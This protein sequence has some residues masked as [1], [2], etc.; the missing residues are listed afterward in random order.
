MTLVSNNVGDVRDI[1]LDLADNIRR[2]P[3][4]LLRVAM[5]DEYM[6]VAVKAATDLRDSTCYDLMAA[7]VTKH[8]SRLP[9]WAHRRWQY[10]V[11]WAQVHGLPTPW[12][13]KPGRPRSAG[14]SQY[15]EIVL[16]D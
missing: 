11:R 3:D 16:P 2:E 12:Q 14:P 5:T 7:R 4:V 9:Y 15:V 10:A 6:R 1:L 13:E 8:N